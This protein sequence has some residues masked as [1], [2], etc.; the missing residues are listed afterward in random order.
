VQAPGVRAGSVEAG[1]VLAGSV[2]ADG[3]V[4]GHPITSVLS[5]TYLV[6]SYWAE[7]VAAKCLVAGHGCFLV[8]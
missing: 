2:R 7:V 5:T 6:L 8:S 1:S 3:I 4:H